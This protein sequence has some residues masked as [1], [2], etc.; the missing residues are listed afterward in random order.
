MKKLIVIATV[1][2]VA[3]MYCK[4]S[5][6]EVWN[7]DFKGVYK[8][9]ETGESV[10][11]LWK[12]KWTGKGQNWKIEGT[13][14][15]GD[16]KSNT[17]GSCDER[18]CKITETYTSGPDKGKVYYWAGTYTDTDTANEKVTNS[19][20]TGTFGNSDSDRTSGGTWNAAAACKMM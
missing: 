13:S 17:V 7:C 3:G 18:N 14:D 2:A 9:K 12:V 10:N 19:T 20:F 16:A 4:K 6:Q 5:D 1:L 11:F 8:V 15:E